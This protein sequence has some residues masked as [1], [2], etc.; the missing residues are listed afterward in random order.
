MVCFVFISPSSHIFLSIIGNNSSPYTFPKRIYY[1]SDVSLI[2]CIKTFVLAHRNVAHVS[3]AY[4]LWSPLIAMTM[5]P[6]QTA[7]KVSGYIL[8][9]SMVKEVWSAF[10]KM[11]QMKKADNIF[12]TKR[13]C[14][15]KC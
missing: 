5:N 9:A 11:Q 8:F 10:D 6:D 12:R 2:L 3:T 14:K 4:V 13:Y 1:I 15:D 7:P